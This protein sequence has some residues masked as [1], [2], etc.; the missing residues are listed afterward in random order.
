MLLPAD[1]K[2][3]FELQRAAGYRTAGVAA[4]QRVRPGMEALRRNRIFYGENRGQRLVVDIHARGAA[5][6]RVQGLPQHPRD[7]LPM[8]HHL[9]GKQRLIA[10]IGARIAVARH[11]G[12]AQRGRHARCGQRRRYI[13]LPHQGVRVRRHHGP[14]VQHLREAAHQIVRVQRLAGHVPARAFVRDR[15]PSDLHAATPVCCSHWN[16]ANRLCASASR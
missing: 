15:L 2:L 4:L 16:F 3:A 6:R 10:A 14:R 11:V 5:L 7:R 13:Q 8:I 9:R 1:G 12:R